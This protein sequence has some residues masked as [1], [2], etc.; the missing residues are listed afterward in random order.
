MRVR[1]TS[2][3]ALLPM[4]LS[5]AACSGGDG[6]TTEL[7]PAGGSAQAGS[8]G[9]GGA[10]KAGTSGQGGALAGQGGGA[11]AGGASAKGGAGGQAGLGG[12]AGSGGSTSAGGASGQGGAGA[13]AGSSGGCSKDGDC[14]AAPTMPPGCAEALCDTKTGK[15]VQYAK[16]ADKDGAPTGKCKALDGV[17]PIVLGEDCDDTN[18]DVNPKGWDGPAGD[19]HPDHCGDGVDQDCS[20]ADDD[21]KLKDGTSCTCSPG[22]TQDCSLDASGKPIKYPGGKPQGICAYGHQTCLD[23]AKWGPCVDAVAPNVEVCDPAS[24]QD[25]DC[26]GLVDDNDPDVMGKKT[27]YCDADS[28][29]YLAPDVVGIESCQQPPK[30]MCKG[31]WVTSGQKTDCDDADP[32]TFPGAQ[33]FCDGVRNDC[34]TTKQ[35]DEGA[36]TP[37]TWY[38]DDDGDKHLLSKELGGPPQKVQCEKPGS[39]AE[40]CPPG[41]SS[42]SDLW[43]KEGSAPFDDCD[44]TNAARFTGNWDGPATTQAGIDDAGLTIEFFQRPA[45]SSM[46]MGGVSTE[47]PLGPAD[48][49]LDT[50]GGVPAVAFNWG[51][52][53]PSTKLDYDWFLMRATGSL[54]IVKDGDYTFYAD[55]VDDGVRLWLGDITAPPTIDDWAWPPTAGK[56]QAT[57]TL[58]AGTYPLRLEYFEITG[59]AYVQLDWSGPDFARELLRI[60]DPTPL[61]TKPDR[62]GDGVDQ[63][64]DGNPDSGKS[65]AVGSTRSCTAAA[66]EPGALVICEAP[67]NTQNNTGA[68]RI[69]RRTCLA[70]GSG[71]GACLDQTDPATDTCGDGIDNDCNGKIDDG[72]ASYCPDGDGD[73]YCDLTQCKA[74]CPGAVPSGWKAQM[75]VCNPASDCAGADGQASVYPNAPE[76]CDGKDNN[77][78]GSVDEGDPGGGSACG[79]GLAGVCSAGTF[80]CQAGQVKCVQNQGA[81]AEVC[82]GKDN[83][84]NGGVDESYPEKGAQCEMSTGLGA[85]RC[86]VRGCTGGSL[87]CNPTT[88]P[89]DYPSFKPNPASCPGL[90]YLDTWDWNCN[91]ND[92]P[93]L[94]P[95]SWCSNSGDYCKTKTTQSACNQNHAD[96]L[97][98]F[99]LTCCGGN[100]CPYP[101]CGQ[102]YHIQQCWWKAGAGCQI[103]ATGGD[104]NVMCR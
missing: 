64:C 86:G 94:N 65:L 44:D 58:T 36:I 41:Q 88:V 24:K 50:L 59:A 19:G 66:C 25:E 92:E 39:A 79:T 95:T 47:D 51:K 71:Y 26:D 3:F 40:D 33:E 45:N 96:N 1:S 6:D 37:A 49:V 87:T 17:T 69:G 97:G 67:T 53:R 43:L 70:D 77:C 7:S 104:S 23:S 27:Y 38:R 100:L 16:D 28:D 60:K 35:P 9:S 52:G 85:C 54:H 22:D 82:D 20:G 21:D 31:Q 15:C 102:V 5:M 62:C 13:A 78:N 18:P 14:M 99:Y 10:G 89:G 84:C 98:V 8:G 75:G 83:N 57:V 46:S 76:L 29:G 2:M 101:G 4:L 63:D 42:C 74:Y 91:G 72:M 55:A 34:D 56:R 81:S 80:H 48:T 68:C 32:K 93:E 12:S 73:G 30:D 90:G 103:G 11:G 61:G